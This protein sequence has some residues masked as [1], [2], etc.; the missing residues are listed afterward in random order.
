MCSTYLRYLAPLKN[1]V[2]PALCRIPFCMIELSSLATSTQNSCPISRERMSHPPKCLAHARHLILTMRG[3]STTTKPRY[4]FVAFSISFSC[5]APPSLLAYS[6][7]ILSSYNLSAS[8]LLIP[9]L[10]ISCL[11]VCVSPAPPSLLLDVV[12]TLRLEECAPALR[13]PEKAADRLAAAEETVSV[14][15][16]R[17]LEPVLATVEES[18]FLTTS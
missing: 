2:S 10:V 11:V 16:L 18:S 14:V 13:L 15:L 3:R 5:Q 9:P 7:S 1:R 8:F 12:V 4:S 6:S 17:M